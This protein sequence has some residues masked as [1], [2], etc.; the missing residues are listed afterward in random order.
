MSWIES[1]LKCGLPNLS[2]EEENYYSALWNF[3]ISGDHD[4]IYSIAR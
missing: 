4:D 3:S 2:D 1:N